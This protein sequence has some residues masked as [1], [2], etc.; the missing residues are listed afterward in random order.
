MAGVIFSE[1]VTESG[2]QVELDRALPGLQAQPGS[3]WVMSVTAVTK[4]VIS[5]G[6]R[7]LPAG[8]SGGLSRLPR[9][10]G[11]PIFPGRTKALVPLGP[12]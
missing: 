8:L 11:L 2:V 6:D 9:D 12:A 7:I 5:R 1:N 10:A 4:R 3:A